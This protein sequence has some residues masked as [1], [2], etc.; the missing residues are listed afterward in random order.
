VSRSSGGSSCA[1]W[2]ITRKYRSI[3]RTGDVMIDLVQEGFDLAI[4]PS[5][6]PDSTLIKRTLAKWH[7]LLC[8]SRA[9]LDLHP[10][11]RT[12]ADLAD[13][14]LLRYAYSPYGPEADFVDPAGSKVTARLSGNLVTTS[15]GRW[16][17]ARAHNGKLRLRLKHIVLRSNIHVPSLRSGPRT[18]CAEPSLFSRLGDVTAL[19]GDNAS[20]IGLPPSISFDRPKRAKSR[21]GGSGKRHGN[22][23]LHQMPPLGGGASHRAAAR[24]STTRGPSSDARSV[25]RSSYSPYGDTPRIADAG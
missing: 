12:P 17:N 25:P 16:P 11:A 2:K 22:S 21:I 18:V 19:T 9:Y 24:R 8:G 23:P 14:N 4:M 7:P 6:P 20:V 5:S 15:K 1:F 3:L 10:A 13:H